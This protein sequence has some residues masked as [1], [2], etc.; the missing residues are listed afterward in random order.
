M[1]RD[2]N[3]CTG[4]TNNKQYLE[5]ILQ[6]L[7]SPYILSLEFNLFIYCFMMSM[8]APIKQSLLETVPPKFGS[9]L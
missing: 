4:K 8:L 1:M 5:E 6:P 9:C 2:D 3:F 7:A